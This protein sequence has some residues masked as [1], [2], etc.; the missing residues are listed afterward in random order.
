MDE[1]RARGLVKIREHIFPREKATVVGVLV[2]V[3]IG[4][5]NAVLGVLFP[6]WLAT[7]GLLV[8]ALLFVLVLHEGLHGLA[9]K[10]LG[11]APIFGVEPPL[12]FTT[13]D[14]LIPRN[15][16]IAIALAPLVILDIAFVAAYVWG[17]W[18][19]FWNLCFAVNTIGALGDC[20]ITLQLLGDAPRHSFRVVRVRCASMSTV[21]QEG[22]VDP[23]L[24]TER[25]GGDH[26]IC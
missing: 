20:W 12:V 3:L 25:A 21:G 6:S 8:L 14:E 17:P 7:L 16:L 1:E 13:F 15:H 22:G 26:G 19:V 11:H 24:F 10:L 4:I 5:G 18:P 23:I 2:G 9:G